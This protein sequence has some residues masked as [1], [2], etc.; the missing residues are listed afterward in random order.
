MESPRYAILLG[1]LQSRSGQLGGGHQLIDDFAPLRARLA[2]EIPGLT[3]VYFSYAAG[4]RLSA[5]RDPRD[6]WRNAQPETGEPIYSPVDT[7]DGPVAEH[8]HALGWLIDELHAKHPEASFDLIGFSLGGIV[9]LAWAAIALPESLRAI[10]R[11]VLIST[12]VGGVTPLG[13]WT[14]LP[15]VRH[16]LERRSIGFGRARVFRDLEPCGSLIAGIR[17]VPAHVDVASIENSRDFLVNGE[18]V[19]GQHLV[20]GWLRTIRLGWGV[21]AT[22]FL[23]ARAQYVADLGGWDRHVRTTHHLILRGEGAEIDAARDHV[24]KL[25]AHDGPRWTAR[26]SGEVRDPRERAAPRVSLSV[27]GASASA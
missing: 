8:V 6:G 21:A 25:L 15:G 20:P 16:L 13:K 22:G 2:N 14:H 11:I 24:A 12:P 7:T 26:R 27:H 19:P 17:D 1:G 10:H 9:A 23:P 18:P 4:P 5:G 3:F